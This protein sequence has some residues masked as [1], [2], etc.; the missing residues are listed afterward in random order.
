MNVGRLFK[1]GNT[2]LSGGEPRK[3]TALRVFL[4]VAALHAV[5]LGPILVF[6][7]CKNAN[8]NEKMTEATDPLITP[9]E[10]EMAPVQPVTNPVVLEA[11]QS[12][13]MPA[14]AAMPDILVNFQSIAW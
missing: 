5:V 9:T 14:V 11:A 6:E 10:T 7:G 8:S 4:I 1:G 2:P 13:P 3:M 12:A